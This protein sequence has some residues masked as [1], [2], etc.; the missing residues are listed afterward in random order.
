MVTITWLLVCS[1]LYYFVIREDLELLRSVVGE[2]TQESFIYQ[3]A[4]IPAHGVE[5][6][7]LFSYQF[8]HA[9]WGHLIANMWYLLVFG[10]ILENAWGALR[11]FSFVAIGGALAVIPEIF[12]QG[13]FSPPIVGASGSAAFILGACVSLFP[14]SKIRMLMLIIPVPSVPSTFFVPLRYLVYAWLFLQAFGLASH[15]WIEAKPVAYTTHLV[16]FGVGLLVGAISWWRSRPSYHD[17]DLSGRDLKRYYEMFRKFQR[18]QVREAQAL[19]MELSERH[20]YSFQ[21]Q[22]QLTRLAIENHQAL[23]AEDLLDKNLQSYVQLR[24]FRELR[25]LLESYRKEFQAMPRLSD[26]MGEELRSL[27]GMGGFWAGLAKELPIRPKE[28]DWSFREINQDAV[29]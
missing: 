9:S 26:E 29:K 18:K 24:R 4:V 1:G 21:L 3:W 10:W 15:Y 27:E 5:W 6:P 8:V 25:S 22:T 19:M 14:R 12:V 20:P 28:K 23:V 7:K 17:V 2:G 11:Y 16:G 13:E